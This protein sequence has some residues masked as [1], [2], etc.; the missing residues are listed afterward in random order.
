MSLETV[1]VP[2]ADV[3]ARPVT[4][5]PRAAWYFALATAI[6]FAGFFPSYFGRLGRA[7]AVHHFHGITAFSWLLL[8]VTQGW[9]AGT[10]RWRWHRLLGRLSLLIAPLLVISGLLVVRVMLRGENPF[11]RAFGARLAFIDFTTL[12]YF[13][14][15]YVLALVYRRN[16]PLHARF[17]ASTAV[18][19]LPPGLARLVARVVP[20]ISFEAAIHTTYALCLLTVAA[21]LWDDRK[22]GR[23]RA[24]YPVL[25]A[26]LLIQQ[27]GFFVMSKG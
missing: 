18:I 12:A 2:V 21:L 24:P 27:V 13:T 9:L 1:R 26:V 14:A 17:M 20:D 3:P 25:G 16:Q 5:Y 22:K 7:D 8:L 4:L 15:A 23:I 11:N 19:A 6:T 10:R